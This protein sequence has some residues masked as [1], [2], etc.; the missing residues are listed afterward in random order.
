[1][2]EKSFTNYQLGIKLNSYIDEKCRVWFKAKGV[3][4]ILGYKNTD[5]AIKRHV[6]ENHKR[7]LL[8]S[9][10]R[11]SRGQVIKDKKSCPPETGG[12]VQGR[13]IILI[14]EA[15]FY[16]LVF[17]SRLPSARIFREWV[18]AK[19]LPSIRKYGYYKMIDSRIKQRV[20][21]EGK[22][23]Y[24]HLVF[25]NYASNKNGDILSLKTKKILSMLKGTNGY[26]FFKLYDKKLEKPIN[27]SQHRF[28]YEVFRGT[29]P[30]C[31]EVDH[32]N[33]IKIDNRIKNLQLLSH[34]NNIEKSKN[35]PI[36]SINIETGKER[37]YNSIKTAAIELDIS[38]GN[39]SK[40]CS[41]KG[42]SL[43]SK[44]NGKKY[45]FR[46]LD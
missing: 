21:F 29:I 13:W 45:T 19:V 39:I 2:Q 5:D 15:G 44:K 12:L 11:E 9:C 17:K 27:Y 6:S 34:K 33:E 4:Q 3:A 36:I 40:V 43:S 30:R 7:K 14:D 32:I 46:Y 18:F 8:L 24:K 35:R 10:P 31:F 22:K 23:Y 38:A 28:V 41:K 25:S 20:I 37:R 1:M 26:L 42:K 16:E